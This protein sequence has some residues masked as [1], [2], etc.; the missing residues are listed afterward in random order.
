MTQALYSQAVKLLQQGKQS[1]A[2]Q[3]FVK[4][5]QKN[6][7]HN[8]GRHYFGLLS[9]L[10]EHFEQGLEPMNR[11]MASSSG[12]KSIRD[13]QIM[14][15]HF[16]FSKQQHATATSLLEVAA[17]YHPSDI[18]IIAQLAKLYLLQDKAKAAYT[19]LQALPSNDDFSTNFHLAIAC[20]LL[21][22]QQQA[23]DAM[24]KALQ[25]L[26]L[27]E[28][29]QQGS[30]GH[31]L[32][33][34]LCYSTDSIPFIPIINRNDVAFSISG[35]HFDAPILL[36]QA[37]IN[38]NRLF[39]SNSELCQ[40]ALNNLEQYD[41]IINTISDVE[42]AHNSLLR[43]QR[44]LEQKS[45]A[46]INS[47]KS[48]LA[49]SRASVYQALKSVDNLLIAETQQLDVHPKPDLA[50]EQFSAIPTPYLLR[51][52]GSSTGIGLEKID[53]VEKST[54]L[55]RSLAGKT[56]NVCP[57]IDFK[58]AD[59][60]YR[61][62]RVFVIGGDILPEHCVVSDHWNVHSSSRLTLML[63]SE[64]YRAEEIAFVKDITSVLQTRHIEAINNIAAQLQL[65]YFGIDFSFTPSGE[66]L[67]F[68]A[69]SGMRVNPDYLKNFSYLRKP[70]E[71][72]ISR[73]QAMM[74]TKT[75]R[76]KAHAE[77]GVV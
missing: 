31:A 10:E 74:Q 38:L 30:R 27:H 49:T 67:V 70:I 43:L 69:N 14:A 3:H 64:T 76:A 19:L 29:G 75:Q 55:F 21:Q 20:Q 1:Q 2:L 11:A 60:H 32:N 6:P 4:L 36:T 77:A 59:G 52:L 58:S 33:I 7:N 47:P 51:P 26:P 39:V 41:L 45:Y 24:L 63:E 46:V 15:S 54:D 65:D 40:K 8:L 22:Q 57:F 73:F 72:I 48:V 50:V 34:L 53:Q 23:S 44:A 12:D 13:N 37:N 61:K 62:Y 18:E 66:L 16:A 56:I 68:E 71:A 35:G 5:L 17:E 42:V 9:I 25:V 28:L